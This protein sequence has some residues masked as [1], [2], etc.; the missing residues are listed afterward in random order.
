MYSLIHAMPHITVAA[1][2]AGSFIPLHRLHWVLVGSIASERVLA[3]VAGSSGGQGYTRGHLLPI[4]TDIQDECL[5]A[6][7]SV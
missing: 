6:V 4:A 2:V 5:R 1:I 7:G 3:G